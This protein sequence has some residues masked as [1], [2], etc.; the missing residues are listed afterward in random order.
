MIG[1]GS[2]I[3]VCT[4]KLSKMSTRFEEQHF[5]KHAK[6]KNTP[7]HAL[8]NIYICCGLNFHC[9]PMGG[10]VRD[11]HQPYSRVFLYHPF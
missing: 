8:K 2:S 3:S 4:G 5:K 1:R 6:T 11:G 10:M 9:F 7:D